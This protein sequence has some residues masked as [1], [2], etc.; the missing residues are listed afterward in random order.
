MA[1]FLAARLP[2]DKGGYRIIIR[3]VSGFQP[4]RLLYDCIAHK[5]P[6]GAKK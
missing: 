5:L 6:N 3:S 2:F 1:S 4:D